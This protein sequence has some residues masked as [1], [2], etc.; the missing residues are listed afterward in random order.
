MKRVVTICF[1][2]C[3]SHQSSWADLTTGLV[4]Y[5]NFDEGSGATAND[6]SG[7]NNDGTITGATWTSSGMYGGALNFDGTNDYVMVPDD[8]SL[9]L[10]G[11][12]TIAAWIN[13]GST[14][15]P[16]VIAA[17]W[18][19]NI[20]QHSYI[21]KDHD[22][23][24]NL[25]IELWGLADIAGTAGIVTGSWIHV[26]ATFDSSTVKLYYNGV[27]DA[28]AVR[29]GSIPASTSALRI[30]AVATGGTVTQNFMGLMDEVYI[31]DRALSVDEINTL[32]SAPVP[33]PPALLLGSI[34]IALAS[35][36]LRKRKTL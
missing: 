33:V 14:S 24:S 35:W 20:G 17:K 34:G 16:R 15:G 23:G 10:S 21:F 11:G 6:L 27:E 3:M 19:D 30:G 29:V 13:S 5:W 7:N 36:R 22:S 31:Y 26:A 32:K 8:D 25:R 28:S 4:G 1:F 12:M 2:I 9:D 18:D